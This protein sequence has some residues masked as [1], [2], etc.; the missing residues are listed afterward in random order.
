MKI[1]QKTA[2]KLFVNSNAV[3]I[4]KPNYPK[5]EYTL[6]FEREIKKLVSRN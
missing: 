2:T 6:A 4:R 1:S 3:G 5:D